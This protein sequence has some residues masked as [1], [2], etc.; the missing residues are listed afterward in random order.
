MKS[1]ITITHIYKVNGYLVVARNA[2]EAINVLTEYLKG[3]IGEH[4]TEDIISLEVIDE[5]C[6]SDALIK[7]PK[8]DISVEDIRNWYMDNIVN[9]QS[10]VEISEKLYKFINSL[11]DESN[12]SNRKR[13]M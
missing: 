7:N 2:V 3:I 6:G 4:H 9:P 10:V 1:S 8:I 5:G 12:T 13:G 11:Q